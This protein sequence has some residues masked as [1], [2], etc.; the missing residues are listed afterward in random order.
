M[1]RCK[2]AEIATPTFLET[3]ATLPIEEQRAALQWLRETVAELG[4]DDAML[5]ERFVD[6][7]PHI[8][9]ISSIN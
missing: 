1:A 2:N 6:R 3:L 4:I 5:V 8:R 7:F 9:T